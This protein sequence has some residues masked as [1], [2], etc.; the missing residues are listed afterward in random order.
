[1]RKLLLAATALACLVPTPGFAQSTPSTAPAMFPFVIPW[2]D[3]T[4]G[5]ATDMSFLNAKP[6][7]VNGA[8]IVKDGHFAEAKT[9]NRVRFLGTNFTFHSNYPTHEDADKIAAHI[10][11]LGINIVRIHH[12]D[13]NPL[14]MWD[15]SAKGHTKID[16]NGIE[17]LDYLIAQFK[18]NGI[19]VDLNLKVSR[20]FTADD[21][22][23]ASIKDVPNYGKRVDQIDRHMIDLQKNFARDYLTHVNQYTGMSYADDPVVAIVEINNEN[24]LSE[25]PGEGTTFFASLPDYFRDET[26]AAWNAYLVKK[27]KTTEA[28]KAAWANADAATGPS[29]FVSSDT[30]W[31]V[32]DSGH[33]I[34]VN[35]VGPGSPTT[36]PDIDVVNPTPSAPNW[37]KQL[38]V[39]H[40]D[41][42]ENNAYVVTFRAKAEKERVIPIYAGVT[43]GDY[44]MIGLNGK[45]KAGPDWRD[46]KYTFVATRTLPKLS[47]IA[48]IIGDEAGAF[49]IA[50]FRISRP[51]PSDIVPT[52]VSLEAKSLGLPDLSTQQQRV[53]WRS[54]LVDTETA[55][56]TEM[57]DYLRKDLKVHANITESQMSYGGVMSLAREAGSDFNDDH[58][59][60]QHPQGS[61]GSVYWKIGNTPMTDSLARWEGGTFAN[62]ATYRIA[63]KPFT[64]SEYCHPAPSD[65]R[66]E[67]FPEI[68]SFAALQ[69]WD[70]IF[71]FDFGGY[72]N[73]RPWEKRFEPFTPDHIQG[74]F[75][76]QGDTTLEA[77]AP[78][79]ALMFR[80]GMIPAASNKA[81]LLLPPSTPYSLTV[82]WIADLWREAGYGKLPDIL[83]NRLEVRI[84]PSV[85][86]PK[87]V[88][89]SAPVAT[90]SSISVSMSNDGSQYV[91][92]GD[93]VIAAAGFFGGTRADFG[94]ASFTFPVFGNSFAA[95]SLVAL[96]AKRIA[97][98]Q[99]MLL[100][101][102]GKCE[103]I[104]MGWNAD[105]TGVGMAWGKGPTQTE[106][107]PATV[108]ISNAL[109]KH[110]WAL[111][112]AGE[113]VK[114]VPVTATAT[115]VTLTIGPQFQTVW[116]EIAL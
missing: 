59:Y 63:G 103:N 52:G 70:I 69:D 83:A 90:P 71:Q 37:A 18:K 116:Y 86:K 107:I 66:A 94:Q 41:L 76:M 28:L 82:R 26:I 62:L 38:E 7:G 42:A 113:R 77:F 67:M 68:M 64:V 35:V 17:K 95:L 21:G 115:G 51:S 79:G 12:H 33:N 93:S 53:D 31:A 74:F 44:H 85:T 100:T 109:V 24:T 106:G 101:I 40:I 39:Q 98:S 50:N 46:F 22:F 97:Q 49:S 110:A 11:K 29:D 23:P 61:L 32:E 96:D 91:A 16:P 10:A 14:P 9:G 60:W 1:M 43:A 111:G 54:F 5:T 13:T 6:A 34:K 108:T 47:R 73:S 27:Y 72:G 19:Y 4:K 57:R 89:S 36:A 55:Y 112:P 102:G 20:V 56:A 80:T 81:T 45:V 65:Y 3:V 84:D 15:Q 88:K 58:A 114:E 78:A 75:A 25:G 105:R 30:K 8:I 87:I 92:K 104:G 99:R 48:F 2:D